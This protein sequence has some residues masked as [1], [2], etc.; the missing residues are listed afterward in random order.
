[1]STFVPTTPALVR[2]SSLDG[3]PLKKNFKNFMW[4]TWKTLF[5]NAP[6]NLMYELGERLQFGPDKDVIMGYRGMSKSYVTVDFAVWTL[7]CDPTELVLTVS[8]SGDGAK[9]NASLAWGMVNGF[10]W[11]AHMK[12]RGI[13]RSSAQAFDVMGSRMEKSESFAA[14]SLFGQI[15]GRRASLIIPDDIETPN[16][17]ATEADRKL[18]RVRD[19]EL[20]GAIL[21]NGGRVKML[22]TAQTEDTIYLEKATKRGYGMRM[23]PA[24]YPRVSI[25]PKL[26]EVHLYGGWLAPSI[27]KAVTDNPHLAGTSTD[28]VRFPDENLLSRELDYGT[29]EFDRQFKLHLHAGAGTAQALKLRDLIV[30]EIPE[31]T[32]EAPLRLP[33]DFQWSPSPSNKWDGI[34]LDSLNGDDAVYAPE[35]ASVGN[36][37]W[38]PPTL[39]ELIIDPSGGGTDETAWNVIAEHVARVFLLKADARLE[40]FSEET[41]KAIA[42]DAYTYKVNRIRIEKNFGGGMF[43]ALLLPYIMALKDPSWN[44]CEIVEENAGMVQKE[45]RIVD[46]L[47]PVVTSHRLVVAAEV[48]RRDWTA[49][50]NYP[51]VE[52]DKRFHYRFTHQFTRI[53]KVKGCL[54]HDDRLDVL[55]SGVRGFMG[56]LG[57]IVKDAQQQAKDAKMAEE[58]DK[59]IEYRRKMGLPLF[60]LEKDH[61]K[62]GQ[63]TLSKG[64]LTKSPLFKHR[65]TP[66][67]IH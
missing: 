67:R 23:W 28:P 41:L 50:E 39:V 3:D 45:V 11:L 56:L 66:G 1:M 27:L 4:K 44:G 37:S 26:D 58:V 24:V 36:Q 5:D 7:Y 6:S 43:G 59:L 18:L 33:E 22:G 34:T 65:S 54:G 47:T 9:G 13:L 46:T 38:R 31:P 52:A 64:G 40:G 12:P 48:L 35:V 16:T 10:D 15:T 42:K 21:K 55:A 29:T 51:T 19:K 20:G 30:M 61:A 57:R 14:M 60:G 53:T 25:D 32:L 63:F 2:R 49:G 8:G 62:L 17:C